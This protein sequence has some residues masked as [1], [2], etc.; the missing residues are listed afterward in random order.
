MIDK[1]FISGFDLNR[2]FKNKSEENKN[3][4][5]NLILK[6]LGNSKI[7]L[8]K[9]YLDNCLFNHEKEEVIQEL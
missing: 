6:F 5:N 8:N 7:N 4:L 2:Y 9:S 3:G 1:S